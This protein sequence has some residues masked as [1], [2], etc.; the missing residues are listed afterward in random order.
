MGI[1]S[2]NP[3]VNLLQL[4]SYPT[5]LAVGY[6]GNGDFFAG[7]NLQFRQILLGLKPY[8]PIHFIP[9]T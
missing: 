1:G 5:I 8:F 6:E 4:S 9:P 2:Q 7:R 3:N